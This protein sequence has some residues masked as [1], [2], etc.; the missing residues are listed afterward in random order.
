MEEVVI[1]V[2]AAVGCGGS[3]TAASCGAAADCGAAGC[4]GGSGTA[5]SCGAAADCGIATCTCATPGA[6]IFALLCAC[7]RENILHKPFGPWD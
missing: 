5:A 1:S 6:P 3:G 7:K 4:G 2:V